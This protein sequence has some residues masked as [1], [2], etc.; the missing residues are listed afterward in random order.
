MK[1]HLRT[2]FVA[3]FLFITAF[4]VVGQED[5]SRPEGLPSRIGGPTCTNSNGRPV[6][7]ISGF[8]YVNGVSNTGTLPK[9]SIAVY[10]SGNFFGRQRLKNGGAFT[11]YCVPRE[12][13][14][15][16]GEV[17]SVEV[18]VVQMGTLSG[19]PMT[20]RQDVNM[21]W[22]DLSGAKQRTGVVSAQNV[23]NR[24]KDNEKRFKKALDQI[25]EGKAADA[26]VEL[27]ELLKNDPKDWAT[28]TILGN[29]D[30]NAGRWDESATAYS[31][32]VELKSDHL[33]AR[34]GLGRAFINLKKLDQA[35]EVLLKAAAIEPKSADVNQ[36]LGEAYFQAKKGTQAIDHF[37]MAL[38]ASPME[39]ADLH[40]R[41][42]ALYQAAGSKDLAAKEYELFLQKRPDYPQRKEMEKFIEENR[43]K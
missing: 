21:T 32:A 3:S 16:I 43:P 18:A 15:L 4:T 37:R 25:E 39:K 17:D 28:W 12:N 1:V 24:S 23:Y 33:S 20:N 7:S 36:Y 29:L 10:A 14:S 19:P 6:A 22:S 8:L 38:E 42:G 35:T 5:L 11:F 40:L 34:I 41:I 31:N 27:H 9:F 30:F 2:L 26:I 13:V